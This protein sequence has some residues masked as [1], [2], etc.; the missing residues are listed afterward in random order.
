VTAFVHRWRKAITK[1]GLLASERLVAHTLAV[2]MNG[3]GGSC[4]PATRTLAGETGLSRSTVQRSLDRLAAAGYIERTLG[5]GRG[6]PTR[7]QAT[8]PEPA[9]SAPKRSDGEALYDPAKRSHGEAHSG[10][11]NGL[12][13]EAETASPDDVNGLT[14]DPKRPHHEARGGLKGED[15]LGGAVSSVSRSP[16]VVG[17]PGGDETDA[18]AAA[19]EQN[20]T[21]EP[22]ELRRL[23]VRDVLPAPAALPVASPNAGEWRTCPACGGD[24]TEPPCERC[25][26]DGGWVVLGGGDET[27]WPADWPEDDETGDHE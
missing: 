26:G 14:G 5:G 25:G 22:S 20:R 13:G 9:E 10:G 24:D 17:D 7:Y 4:H 21:G 15:L 8:I 27:Y 16:Q 12:T 1:S 6:R 2:H 18:P 23:D 11:G 3:D 19:E